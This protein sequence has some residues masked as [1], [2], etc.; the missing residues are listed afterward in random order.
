MMSV[1]G[2]SVVSMRYIMKTE[3][4]EVLENTMKNNPVSY[5]H[6]A[7]GIHPMLQAQLEGSKAGDTKRVYL[8]AATGASLPA[9]I[10]EVIIDNIRAAM[11]EELALGY[12]VQLAA[13]PCEADCDCYVHHEQMK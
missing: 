9:L 6:G 8:D 11:P 13:K 12:P 1:A 3:A 7:A 4:G 10:F 2:N 5:L